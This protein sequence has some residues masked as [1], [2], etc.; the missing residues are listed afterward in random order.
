MVPTCHSGH[1]DVDRHDTHMPLM[2]RFETAR[3]DDV[4][5]AGAAHGRREVCSRGRCPLGAR[6][7]QA[8]VVC[9]TA[10]RVSG[11]AAG[12]HAYYRNSYACIRSH[13]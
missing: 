4:E 5:T 2:P 6:E 8:R 12:V 7:R 11:G 3:A 9:E 10:R 1:H 13:G